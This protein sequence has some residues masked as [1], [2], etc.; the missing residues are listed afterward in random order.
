M[1]PIRTDVNVLSQSQLV[2]FNRRSTNRSFGRHRMCDIYKWFDYYWLE[3]R[4][5]NKLHSFDCCS[6]SLY[7]LTA[8]RLSQN[9]VI[10]KNLRCGLFK[11]CCS[12]VYVRLLTFGL[13]NTV[14]KLPFL[15]RL[16]SFSWFIHLL[17][18]MSTNYPSNKRKS[19]RLRR[20]FS[21]I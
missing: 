2:L 9:S 13:K 19:N 14:G 10:T 3:T 15:L 16:G 6:L 20:F 18:T 17:S 4:K 1:K 21:R 8:A 5:F 11:S 12:F 7:T